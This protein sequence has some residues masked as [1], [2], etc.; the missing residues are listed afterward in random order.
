L[1][2]ILS[3][4][5][6]RRPTPFTRAVCLLAAAQ[7]ACMGLSATCAAQAVQPREA[8]E[9]ARLYF[10]APLRW[11]QRDWLEFGGTLVVLGIAHQ[12]DDDIREH[13]VQNSSDALSGKDPNSASDALPAAILVAGTWILAGALDDPGGYRELGSML[14]ATVLSAAST[15]ILKYAT[16]RQRPNETTD[17][18][19]WFSGGDSFAS[20]HA[21]AAFAIGT[22][23]AESG[24]DK[25]RWLRRFVGYGVAGVTAYSRVEHNAHW[26]SDVLAGA[27]LGLSTANFTMHR[28]DGTPS[29]TSAMLVPVDRGLMLT[30]LVPLR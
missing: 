27:A 29:S 19:K 16:G 3:H 10:T 14:E 12:Y 15:G 8:L 2:E 30:F 6:P 24:D 26:T 13:F 18:N 17:P 23:F 5:R 1:I 20:L 22:V 9:D 25:Y 7:I 28:R 11:E 21:S 4:E